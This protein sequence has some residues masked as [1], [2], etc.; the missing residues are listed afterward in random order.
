L[1]DKTGSPAWYSPLTRI[2]LMAPDQLCWGRTGRI[3][4]PLDHRLNGA[5]QRFGLVSYRS[6]TTSVATRSG[7]TTVVFPKGRG[8]LITTFPPASLGSVASSL[9]PGSSV[10]VTGFEVVLPEPAGTH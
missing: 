8:T 9:Q 7:G 5:E 10:C 3:V 4:V 1:T 2:H 6:A